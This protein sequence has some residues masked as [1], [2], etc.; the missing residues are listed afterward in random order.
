MGKPVQ[1]AMTAA[2]IIHTPIIHPAARGKIHRKDR[3]AA[4]VKAAL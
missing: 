4:H 3:Y 2:G 1:R